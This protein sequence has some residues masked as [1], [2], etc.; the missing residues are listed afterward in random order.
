MP[1]GKSVQIVFIGAEDL[2]NVGRSDVPR[3]NA[4]V[5]RKPGASQGASRNRAITG[6][7]L[8]PIADLFGELPKCGRS[9]DLPGETSDS[10]DLNQH[11]NHEYGCPHVNQLSGLHPNRSSKEQESVPERIALHCEISKI[12]KGGVTL[13]FAML[14]GQQRPSLLGPLANEIH[15]SLHRRKI[16]R[17]AVLWFAIPDQI[18]RDER[19]LTDFGQCE[20]E[21]P[22]LGSLRT[23]KIEARI[24]TTNQVQTCVP[25]KR[26]TGVAQKVLLEQCR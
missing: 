9:P 5:L 8:Q 11:S 19:E 14:F 22:V 6:V 10:E 16:R 25:N 1:A 17:H 13:P 7:L 12:Q 26:C 24:V 21:L 18:A 15:G 3:L 4:T 23:A 2:P 20:I